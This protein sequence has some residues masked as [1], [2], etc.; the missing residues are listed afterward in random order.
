MNKDHHLSDKINRSSLGFRS[1]FFTRFTNHYLG[2]Y[3]L[4]IW[5]LSISSSLEAQIISFSKTNLLGAN[6]TEPTSLQFGP[7][8][9]LYVSERSG[10]IFAYTITK[11]G[12]NFQVTATETIDLVKNIPNHDDNGTLNVFVVNRQ[13]TG[14]LV[15]GTAENPQLYVSSS[16]IRVGGGGGGDTNLDTNSG[17]ISHLTYNGSAWTKVDL[18]RG[19]PRSEENH[20]T[21]GLEYDA[22][23]HKLIVAQGGNTNAGAPSANFDHLCEYALSAAILEIDLTMLEAMPILTDLISGEQYVYDIPTLDDPTR[24]ND[25][26]GNDINDPFGGNDGLNQAKYI[27]DGP[28]FIYST[29]YRNQYDVVLT[30]LGHLYTW[31]NGP[32][33]GVGGH[34][35][36]EGTPNVNNN[37]PPGEPGSTGPGPN[38]G[39][40]NN[41][42][43]LHKV[44]QGYYAGHPTPIRG[45]PVGAG[46]FTHESG[47]SS[48]GTFRTAITGDPST[49]LPIDW[50]PYPAS[51]RDL[52][53][54]DY[55]NPGVSDGSLYLIG[56]STNGMV[57]YTANTFNGAMKGDLLAVS[58]TGDVFRVDLDANGDLGPNGVSSIGNQLGIPLDVTTLPNNSQF[59]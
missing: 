10:S 16:D 50:P 27:P 23:N 18:I 13:V 6:L 49:T 58:F 2:L 41:Q 51:L 12:T 19:L 20:A 1:A 48:T 32:N 31:D 55:Q 26:N 15:M 52:R 45:N 3:T 33:Q 36:N 56:A 11:V 7:D 14:I 35:E 22:S 8:G 43:G 38:D 24:P 47:P 59:A 17:I 34:P 46:L 29:G 54:S 28:I 57:E 4:L 5:V 44:T 39:Q 30:E 40:V 37:W 9:R 25:I 42:D 21:N 53:E